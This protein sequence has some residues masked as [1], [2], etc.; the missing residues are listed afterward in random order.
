[1]GKRGITTIIGIAA[2][3][4]LFAAQPAAA[5]TLVGNQ[6]QGNT[7]LSNVTTLSTANAPGNPLPARVPSAGV[8][9]SW[10]FNVVPIPPGVLTQTL[11]IFRA[12]GAP[13]QF[14]AV[15]ESS[16]APIVTGSNSFGT[17]ISVQAGDYLGTSGSASGTVVTVFCNTGNPGDRM[18]I[19]TGNVTSGATATLLTEEAAR[20]NP[21]TA[22]I[23][24]DADN[25]GYGDETQ[26]K[27]PQSATTQA[28]CPVIALSTSSSVK[29][30]LATVL[31]TS[32]LQAAVTVGG[33]VKLGK[34][35]TATLSGGTQVVLPGVISKF[36]LLFTKQLKDKLKSLSRKRSLTLNLTASAPNVIGAP[37]ISAL[38][39]KLKGQ[40]KAKRK[41]RS[42]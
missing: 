2:V 19:M 22:T 1:M 38:S 15:G 5:S 20:Q 37:T 25:D 4:T 8:V 23:E 32:S 40:K 11:K 16:P 39:V 26:D 36:T 27:C 21:I 6:C 33:T 17:R 29:K 9:T 30:G 10:T 13:N 42:R 28:P 18:G 12:T 14:Q 34:G 24:P 31:V 41:N 35:K 3:L 7:S